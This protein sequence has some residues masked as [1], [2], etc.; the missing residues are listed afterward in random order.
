MKGNKRECG[1]YRGISL[2]SHAGKVL[3]NVVA[4]R[5]SAYCEAEGLLSEEQWGFQ[6][7]PSTTEIMFVV[8]M[9]YKI[10]EEHERLS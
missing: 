7:D 3:L 10:S 9:L 6:P 1:N 2:E 4:R 5:L 8:R